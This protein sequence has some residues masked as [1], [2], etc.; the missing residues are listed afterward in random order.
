MGED[1]SLMGNGQVRTGRSMSDWEEGCAQ[2]HSTSPPNSCL[3][4]ALW[5]DELVAA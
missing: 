1:T 3:L 5:T 4:H 2:L